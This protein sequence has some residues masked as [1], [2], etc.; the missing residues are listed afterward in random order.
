MTGAVL[1]ALLPAVILTAL[2]MVLRN[3]QSLADSFWPQAERLG[4]FVL[5]PCLFFHGLATTQV[6]ALPV[7]DLAQTLI[8]ATV[9]VAAL[10][11]TLRP[12]MKIDGPAFT[13]VFQGSVRFNNYVG[14]TLAA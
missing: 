8:L 12:L 1:L 10:V 4:Y 2:G 13:S 3:R 9:A 11:V 7:D 5:L 14:V 6:E